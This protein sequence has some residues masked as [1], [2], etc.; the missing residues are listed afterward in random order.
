MT[1][2][3]ADGPQFLGWWIALLAVL[4]MLSVGAALIA[5][6]CLGPALV[7]GWLDHASNRGDSGVSL[8]Q[9]SLIEK[10]GRF[11][12]ALLLA[13]AVVAWIRLSDLVATISQLGQL[14]Q[15]EARALFRSLAVS[16][17]QPAWPW[18][19]LVALSTIAGIALRLL[20]INQPMRTDEAQTFLFYA[21]KPL[22]IGISNYAA[23]NNHLLNTFLCHFSIVVFGNHPWAIR[24]PAL[25]AG[26]MLIPLTFIV[27]T[28][29]YSPAVGAIAAS[30]VTVCSVLVEYSTN[31]RGYTMQAA[32]VL[33]MVFFMSKCLQQPNWF[34]AFCAGAAAALAFW[35][36]PTT[37]YPFCAAMVWWAMAGGTRAEQSV[38]A[39]R[40]RWRQIGFT[41]SVTIAL[42]ALLYS[43][44]FFARG[45]SAVTA[46]SYV[47][48]LPW[49]QFM[50][51]LPK[52]LAASASLWMRG[53]PAEVLALLLVVF[54]IIGLLRPP[55]GQR[56][57]FALTLLLAIAV[58]LGAQRV[59]PFP[60]VWIFAIPMFSIAV[61]AGIDVLA[62]RL[63]QGGPLA[64][65][66]VILLSALFAVTEVRLS[67]VTRSE[68]TG[69]LP[70]GPQIADFL[71]TRVRVNDRVVLGAYLDLPLSYYLKTRGVPV[72]AFDL[73]SL[74]PKG[75]AV[76]LVD[77][78][79]VATLGMALASLNQATHANNA[80][81]PKAIAKIGQSTVYV[82]VR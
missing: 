61:G 37:L 27:G 18:W 38:A 77:R 15:R 46:N 43:P 5:A 79:P 58:L 7:R 35:T 11:A 70:D 54:A 44:V 20:Y 52:M 56:V 3:A 59:L 39:R 26:I 82:V 51:G 47:V 32:L 75:G 14:M 12:G 8:V 22:L 31:A 71:A 57:S 45:I 62:R 28:D 4:A 67:L 17:K 36:I 63:P 80:L 48:P 50:A 6:S 42:A 29:W 76:Y 78:P 34:A 66:A 30:V 19:A 24:L 2:E 40:L 65:G 60:R 64:V 9:I 41:L 13:L 68:E 72:S 55:K 74:P 16:L 33:M 69:L 73:K 81:A 1:D 21:S 10:K 53:T 23:P 25:V 49:H